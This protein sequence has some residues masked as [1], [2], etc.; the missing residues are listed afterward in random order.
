MTED[1]WCLNCGYPLKLKQVRDNWG[2]HLSFY[3]GKTG[4]IIAGIQACPRC[5][6]WPLDVYGIESKESADALLQRL[7]PWQHND[8]AGELAS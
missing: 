7:E 1:K 5:L 4:R 6:N 8:H 3:D 2:E